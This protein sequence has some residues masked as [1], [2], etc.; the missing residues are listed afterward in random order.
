MSTELNAPADAGTLLNLDD[1]VDIEDDADEAE[2]TE[3]ILFITKLL[4]ELQVPKD[5]FTGYLLKNYGLDKLEK[6]SVEQLEQ[7]LNHAQEVKKKRNE[8]PKDVKQKEAKPGEPPRPQPLP[9]IRIQPGI[10]GVEPRLCEIGKI[11]I[12]EIEIRNGKRI[13]KKLNHFV[14]TGLE[15]DNENMLI[16]DTDVMSI[17]GEQS[18]ELG[19]YLC[20]D[21]P[22]LNIP[23]FFTHYTA[24]RLHCYGD[25][26][27]ALR[28]TEN[29]ERTPVP[30]NIETCPFFLEK[31]CRPYGKMSVIL[32]AAQR[33]GGVYVFR[34]SSWNTIRQIKSS[35]A[36]IRTFTGGVLAGIPLTLRIVTMPVQ[37]KDVGKM[38]KIQTVNLEF[39]GTLADLKE[40][41][42]VEI[43]R[44][45][46]TKMDMRKIEE[47]SKPQLE[48]ALNTEIKEAT[49]EL[50]EEREEPDE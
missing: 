31:K 13:P 37:P 40:T 9:I 49:E 25:G 22:D 35:M 24:S 15:R 34:T 7:V 45:V 29:N 16:P 48:A 4:E 26:V 1:F 28:W 18:K 33:I 27:H 14:I 38:M 36:I 41:A 8:P 20:Y 43:T 19:V 39:A 5:T 42:D 12:G 23:T 3:R 44:R 2:R 47:L 17:V 11:K 32:H 46:N 50:V 30:C 10:K 6:L 21:D